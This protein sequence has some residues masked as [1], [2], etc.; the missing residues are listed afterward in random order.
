MHSKNNNIEFMIN[1]EA[2]EVI[3]E[4]FQSILSRYRIGLEI[5]MKVYIINFIK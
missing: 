1:D 4:L 3:K 2:E 5:L